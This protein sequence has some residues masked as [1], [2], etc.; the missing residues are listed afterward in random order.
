MDEK[1]GST[2][3][4]L[5]ECDKLETMISGARSSDRLVGFESLHADS[6][7]GEQ[8]QLDAP[9]AV[10]I[11]AG[12][13][14][15]QL[16]ARLARRGRKVALITGAP[17]PPRRLIDGCSLRRATVQ[18]MAEAMG[19]DELDLLE[20]LRAGQSSFRRLRITTTRHAAPL[21]D[22][23][24]EAG[25]GDDRE[26][27]GLSARHADIVCALRRLVPYEVALV[28]G[29]VLG[30]TIDQHRLRLRLP[31]GGECDWPLSPRTTIVNTQSKRVCGTALPVKRW[32]AAAQQPL[33]MQKGTLDAI[34]WAPAFAGDV[35]PQLGFVTPFWDS[36]NRDANAYAINTTVIDDATLQAR[37][38]DAVLADIRAGLARC[39]VALGATALDPDETTGAAVVPVVEDF[40]PALEG[41]LLE[42]YAA[43]SPGA[44]AIN[45]DGMLAQSVGVAALCGALGE[46]LGDERRW[47]EACRAVA[48]ALAPLRR[49]NR[50]TAWNYFAAPW[51]IRDLNRR[52][53]SLLGEKV[54]RS[55][56]DLGRA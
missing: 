56:A 21:V 51:L 22:G 25:A 1:C 4:P 8:R 34:A 47:L 48:A 9:D 29:D 28:P 31:T 30:Y 36:Q 27:I 6:A 17:L 2:I 5:D 12:I 41:G 39:V 55:W 10:V 42:L 7:W 3:G 49:I 33:V 40:S 20:A 52:S 43:L 45:V 15:T 26:L 18:T 54:V 24:F 50:F 32:V 37:S 16:A 23:Q 19:V 44:P 13:A 38:R 14:G 35:A 53:L 11:G 46:D